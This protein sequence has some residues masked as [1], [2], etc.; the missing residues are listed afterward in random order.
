MFYK[1]QLMVYNLGIHNC[2]YETGHMHVWHQTDALL[3]SELVAD[4]QAAK[5][6]TKNV[7]V[8]TFDLQSTLPTPSMSTNVVFY[9]RQLMVYN[10][11]IHN[12]KYETGH[13]HVWH[14][15]DALLVSYHFST[16]YSFLYTSTEQ[17]ILSFPCRHDNKNL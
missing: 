13:M 3:W 6:L 1:R 10:L 5:D 11:G 2:K 12:C 4:R 8:I 7:T 15:T 17:Q 9:K 14:Q 16:L